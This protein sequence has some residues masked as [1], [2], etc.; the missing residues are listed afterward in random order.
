MYAEQMAVTLQRF[1][2][3]VVPWHCVDSE[4]VVAA[5]RAIDGPVS[6]REPG[7]LSAGDRGN[8]PK[9]PGANAEEGYN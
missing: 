2:A 4:R 7:E 9:S 3:Q 5:S 6:K 1:N 8:V